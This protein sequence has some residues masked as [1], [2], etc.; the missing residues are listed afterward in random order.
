MQKNNSLNYNINLSQFKEIKPLII[1]SCALL[2]CMVGA[3]AVAYKIISIFGLWSANGAALLFTFTFPIGVLIAEV[4]GSKIG[5]FVTYTAM[6]LSLCF[7]LIV[8]LV[9]H[10]PAPTTIQHDE[11]FRLVLGNSLRFS[12]VGTISS[13]IA[14]RINIAI[15][16]H[17]KKITQGRFFILRYL[18]STTFGELILATLAT[19]GAFL[20][21]IPLSKVIQLW[22]FSYFFKVAIT[23][24]L[25]WP[26]TILA[27]YIKKISGVDVY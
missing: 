18:G 10:L 12:V 14:F 25:A 21:V 24:L 13:I 11:A 9:I 3:N 22:L 6:A 8:V 1:L 15:I 17:F 2:M 26:T 23:S 7:S 16:T 5:K 19:F 20:F 4:Y 27:V